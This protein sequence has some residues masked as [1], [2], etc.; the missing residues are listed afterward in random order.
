MAK[1]FAARIWQLGCTR[2]EGFGLSVKFSQNQCDHGVG[3][4]ISQIRPKFDTATSTFQNYH[5]IR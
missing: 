3:L 2:V 1:V 4:K 5:Y